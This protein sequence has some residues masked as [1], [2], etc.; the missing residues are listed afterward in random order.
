MQID[1]YVEQVRDQLV[2][3]AALG[4]DRVHQVANAL[5]SAA[6]PAVRL[7]VLGALAAAADEITAALL[8]SPGS[9]TVA[10]HLDADEVR[11]AVERGQRRRVRPADGRAP[12]LARRRRCVCADLAAPVRSAQD[13][14]RRGGDSLGPVGQLMAGSGRDLSARPPVRSQSGRGGASQHV[15]GWING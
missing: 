2:A 6:L 7:A 3:A 10:V 15:T 9:P 12:T 5:A 1:S 14:G 4:D 8:D 13:R 11:I